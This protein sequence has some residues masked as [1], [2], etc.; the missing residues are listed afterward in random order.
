ME[1]IAEG[2]SSRRCQVV[3]KRKTGEKKPIVVWLKSLVKRLT[4]E[5]KSAKGAK[6]LNDQKRKRMLYIA[7]CTW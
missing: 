4:I 3:S 1:L 2:I 7:G 5:K 6:S